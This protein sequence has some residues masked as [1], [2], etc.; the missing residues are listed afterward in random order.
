MRLQSDDITASDGGECS[1]MRSG[2]W[3]RQGLFTAD[4]V[5]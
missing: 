5:E 4:F 2:T 1:A 3:A